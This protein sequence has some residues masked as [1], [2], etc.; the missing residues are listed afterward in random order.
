LEYPNAVWHSDIHDV[1]LF[2]RMQIFTHVFPCIFTVHERYGQYQ[3]G[4]SPPCMM[5]DA[6]VKSGWL[7][8]EEK[9]RPNA[10]SVSVS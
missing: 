6:L 1:G 10:R 2:N 5:H 4:N 8:K 3:Y 9:V 7:K